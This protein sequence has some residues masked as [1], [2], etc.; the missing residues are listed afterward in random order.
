MIET[1]L[2]RAVG[3]AWSKAL[4]LAGLEIVPELIERIVV[5]PERRIAGRFDRIVRRKVDGR[6]AILD[7]KSGKSAIDYPHSLAIQLAGYSNAPLM[8]ILAEDETST[9]N[10]EPLPDMDLDLGYVIHLPSPEKVAVFG[11]DL[12]VARK[13]LLDVC[14]ATLEWRERKDIIVPC[15][16][17]PVE[18]VEPP[19]EKLA[20]VTTKRDRPLKVDPEKVAAE[21]RARLIEQ[22]GNHTTPIDARRAWL[23]ARLQHMLKDLPNLDTVI[24]GNWPADTPSIGKANDEQLDS[25]NE[26]FNELSA[27][28]EIPFGP[29]LADFIWADSSL[30]IEKLAAVFG[31]V[32]G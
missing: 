27:E 28:N 7:L 5:Y 17:V 31:G 10:F 24:T 32:I 29:A 9:E 4:D 14:F 25:I 16:E 8:A 19:P 2:S 13:V 26:L 6:H 3:A 18:G 21:R 22:P 11:V 12:T 30:D 23:K 20:K 1:E 15:V